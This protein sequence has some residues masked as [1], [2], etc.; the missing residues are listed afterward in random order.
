MNKKIKP[1]LLTF[2]LLAAIAGGV[3]Y[4]VFQ[5]GD[6][7]EGIVYGNGRIEAQSID[8]ATRHGGRVLS[9]PVEEG[10]MVESGDIVAELDLSDLAASLAGAEA[11][12]RASIQ[13][14]DAAASTVTQADLPLRWQIK[15]SHGP[16]NWPA[17]RPS[18]KAAAT[19]L[20][21]PSNPPR[22]SWPP[23]NRILPALRKALKSPGRKLPV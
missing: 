21:T 13:K 10:Q 19:R 14:R 4:T 22:R 23:Q 3:Y 11:N 8:I 2:A 12:V 20:L 17:T 6:D 1:I 15:N 18:Q 9:V 16:T 5:T 7:L